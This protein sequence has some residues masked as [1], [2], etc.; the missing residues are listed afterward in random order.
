MQD[1]LPIIL[2]CFAASITPGPNT[3][4]LMT[5]GL[6]HGVYKT[7]PLF[8]GVITGFPLMLT[9]LAM[10]LG[11]VFVKFPAAHQ[12][13]KIAGSAYLL[14]LAYKIASTRTV[15][16]DKR[17]EKP[18]TFL[19]GMAFQWLNPKA[20]VV[21][22]GALAAFTDV[23]EFT[24]QFVRVL[25]SFFGVGSLCMVVWMCFGAALNRFIHNRKMLQIF[26]IVMGLLLAVSVIPMLSGETINL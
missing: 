14:Y 6:N 1:L 21:A 26:N 18:L 16:D 9:A 22:V 13:I 25:L 7:L 2:F 15:D 24:V 8:L 17:R 19:Q 4:M 11:V 12:F 20:W 23:G 10:G 3:I 5:S